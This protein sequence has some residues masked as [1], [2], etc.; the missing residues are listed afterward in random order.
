[1]ATK[2]NIM[3]PET[4]GE[5]LACAA[6]LL[7]IAVLLMVGC[8]VKFEPEKTTMFRG[9]VKQIIPNRGD[10]DAVLKTDVDGRVY[11]FWMNQCPVWVNEH[12]EIIGFERGPNNIAPTQCREIQ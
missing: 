9:T 4:F 5:K 12:V 2:E 10:G 11:R 3:P 6:L 8:G 1:M 7:L